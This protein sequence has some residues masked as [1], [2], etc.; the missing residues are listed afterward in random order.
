MRSLCQVSPK[1]TL[2]KKI[3]EERRQSY[4]R[5]ATGLVQFAVFIEKAEAQ[6]WPVLIRN[7]GWVKCE[8]IVIAA[9]IRY[10]SDEVVANEDI[11]CMLH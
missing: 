10:R 9:E 8:R 3:R 11:K 5:R 7:E 2:G 1:V 6:D 4:L